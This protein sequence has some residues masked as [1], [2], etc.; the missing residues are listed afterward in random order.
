M[1]SSFMLDMI[2]RVMDEKLEIKDIPLSR[3]TLH[4]QAQ[5]FTTTTASTS[6]TE[7]NKKEFPLSKMFTSID[8][9]EVSSS[10]AKAIGSVT[11]IL[12]RHHNLN[13]YIDLA[14]GLVQ[15]VETNGPHL[16]EKIGKM[17]LPVLLTGL[18]IT[19][20]LFSSVSSNDPV[21]LDFSVNCMDLLQSIQNNLSSFIS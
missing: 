16:R 5:V 14:E 3:H 18:G 21:V 7:G 8:D 11:N 20:S 2:M 15:I 1:V 12:T 10:A 9:A 6:A 13:T 17:N 19:A 4:I